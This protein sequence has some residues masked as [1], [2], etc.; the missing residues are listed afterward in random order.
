MRTT[1][2]QKT[3]KTLNHPSKKKKPLETKKKLQKPKIMPQPKKIV[4]KEVKPKVKEYSNA[5]IEP[6]VEQDKPPKKIWYDG[7][8]IDRTITGEI[9]PNGKIECMMS[10]GSTRKVP[11]GIFEGEE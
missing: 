4:K 6:V 7:A 8:F 11:K 3:K 1:C 9:L 2:N 5:P 10:D